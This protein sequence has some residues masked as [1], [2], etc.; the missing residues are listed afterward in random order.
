MVGLIDFHQ[1]E[2]LRR[3]NR[4]LT[5]ADFD[6]VF[7]AAEFR[8][9]RPP[10]LL[11]AASNPTSSGRIGTVVSKKVAGTA[12]NRNRIRRVIKESFRQ[13]CHEGK[14]DIV[15]VARPPARDAVN[16]DLFVTLEAMWS[17][18]AKKRWK[19]L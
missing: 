7:A 17:A 11:L 8:F 1:S 19:Q 5:K 15:V 2:Q 12:V 4:L 16:S 3:Q 9:S 14:I 18:L 13:R 10:F 6:R